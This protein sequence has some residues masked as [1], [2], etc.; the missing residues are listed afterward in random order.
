MIK[1]P[2]TFQ[3]YADNPDGGSVMTNRQLYKQMYT[4]KFNKILIRENGNIHYELYI[5]N[6]K[7]DTHYVYI[8]IPS[9]V[10]PNFYYDVVI[11]LYTDKN[12]YKDS[13]KLRNYYV[14]FFSNDPAFVYTFAHSFSKNDLFIK[15]L[16]PKM[17]KEALKN[18]ATIRNPKDVVGYVKSLYFAYLVMERYDL[19]SKVKFNTNCS[20]Y[21]KKDLLN[22]I[23]DA[24]KKIAARQE[25]AE[26]LEKEKK[27]EKQKPKEKH[28]D[29]FVGTTR[30]TKTTKVS[31]IQKITNTSK[32]TKITRKK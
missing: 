19:F 10:V 27:K 13:T 3:Q 14:K 9:E 7:N 5:T 22:K 6:D 12:E 28:S 23:T 15:D 25:E 16:E 2:I 29:N 1:K 26:K 18:T 21:N 20:K 11:Q 32:K 8:K 4:D 17:S 31:K 24:N 30:T